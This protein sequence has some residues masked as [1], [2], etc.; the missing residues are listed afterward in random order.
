MLVATMDIIVLK[1]LGKEQLVVVPRTSAPPAQ[2]A[3]E[4]IRWNQKN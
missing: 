2:I 1:Q 3:Q 4:V